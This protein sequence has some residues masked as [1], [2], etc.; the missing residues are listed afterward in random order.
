VRVA[1]AF[2][3]MALMKSTNMTRIL[4]TKKSVTPVVAADDPRWARI[5]VRDHTADGL[6]WYSVMTTR[7][8]CRP[9]CASRRANPK[10]VQLHEA[11]RATGFRPC[12]RCNHR[13][14]APKSMQAVAGA[15]AANNLAAAIPLSSRHTERLEREGSH[16]R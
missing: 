7:V 4:E 10:N 16:R 12:R 13:I 3:T 1:Q 8:Y 5:L 2:V 6:F 15:C 11:A 14:G 9:S